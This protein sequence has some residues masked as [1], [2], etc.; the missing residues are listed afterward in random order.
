MRR[1]AQRLFT[2]CTAAS[3]VLC[4]AAVAVWVRSYHVRDWFSYQ[5]EVGADSRQWHVSVGL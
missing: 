4:L 1:L 3:L 5:S 2:L